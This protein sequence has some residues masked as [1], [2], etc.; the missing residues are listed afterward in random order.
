MNLEEGFSVLKFIEPMSS[1]H[2]ILDIGANDGT[3]IRMIR[4]YFP[5]TPLVAFDP[6]CTPT[7]DIS[8]I[9]FYNVALTDFNG[10]AE[11]HVP[12]FMD[13]RLT[14]YS[15]LSSAQLKSQIV[16]DF[17]V[18]D[19]KVYIESKS[20]KVMTLDSLNLRPFFVKIDVEGSELSVLQGARKTLSEF[21]PVILIEIQNQE[22]FNDIANFLSGFSYKHISLDLKANLNNTFFDRNFDSGY[23]SE[24]NN[25]VWVSYP[26]TS[27]WKFKD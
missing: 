27:S 1:S 3:S 8:D 2:Q 18:N 9:E 11:V 20:V 14:Q 23:N 15:S 6:V 21:T 24:S 4:R 13:K 17:G 5:K 25:Y 16:H 7:F 26:N 22:T 19:S 12:R 10:T